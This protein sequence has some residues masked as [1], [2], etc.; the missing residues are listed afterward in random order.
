MVMV[1]ALKLVWHLG[2]IEKRK[3]RDSLFLLTGYSETRLRLN[4]QTQ[5]SEK[6]QNET[7]KINILGS[8]PL[9]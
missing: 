7:E 5:V 6:T 3:W 2:R 1:V 4:S 9:P 8:S